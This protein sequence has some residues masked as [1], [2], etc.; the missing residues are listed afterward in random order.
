MEP[1][2]GHWAGSGLE[3]S[4]E[5]LKGR[6]LLMRVSPA[7]ALEGIAVSLPPL[8]P[9]SL[10]GLIL[11]SPTQAPVT[12]I[13]IHKRF[14]ELRRESAQRRELLRGEGI[15][16][17]DDVLLDA[18]GIAQ[19]R[20]IPF[21][22]RSDWWTQVAPEPLLPGFFEALVGMKVGDVGEV[23]L[24]L[25]S[26]YPVE[27][28]RDVPARFI[29][30]VKAAQEL[31]AP[32]EESAA[33]MALLGRGAT[34]DDV[35]QRIGEELQD[36]GEAEVVREVRERVLEILVE[37]SEVAVPADLVD[38]EIRRKWM[39]AE[40]PVLLRRG[41]SSEELQNAL[42]NWLREPYARGEASR[43]LQVALVLGA[44]AAHERIQPR[45]QD[46]DMLC[47]SLAGT[48]QLTRAELKRVLTVTP[49]LAQGVHDL[50]LHFATVDHIMS[51]VTLEV[52][53]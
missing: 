31:L 19:G 17:G 4:L 48:T 52:S 7:V 33:F 8:N 46:M 28:L 3:S 37:R 53:A 26:D 39:A 6:M 18:M 2:S 12:G 22:T 49:T 11:A 14:L 51:K 21:S 24:T 36:E 16:E 10:D 45:E 34:I 27:K 32:D 41:L 38:E 50:L 44:V 42:D 29:V 1:Q 30:E 40:R 5:E 47:E 35:M 23:T 20:L 13:N 9:P 43:R 25:P 15:A